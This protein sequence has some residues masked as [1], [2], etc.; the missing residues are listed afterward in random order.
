M[1]RLFAIPIFFLITFLIII[2]LVLPKAGK[3]GNLE[4][5]IARLEDSVQKAEEHFLTLQ[6]TAEELEDF[7]ES[8][9]KIETALPK[10]LSLASLLNFFE[11]QAE[12]NGLI[13]SGLEQTVAGANPKRRR[14]G[15]EEVKKKVAE[16]YIQ[17][18]LS[19]A[20]GSLEGFLKS[21]E[22]SSRFIGVESIN[23]SEGEDELPQFTLMLKVY[24]Q[25]N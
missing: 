15:E 18:S 23:S 8:L 20:L 24:T 19:G 9:A 2:Y 12:E 14:A 5:Q 22:K 3:L 16:H 25:N 7:D 17:L 13:I 11:A 4:K 1:K 10:E 6:K 21:I